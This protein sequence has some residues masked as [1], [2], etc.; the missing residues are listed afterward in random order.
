MSLYG[1]NWICGGIAYVLGFVFSKNP[2][3]LDTLD[4]KVGRY[5]A[6]CCACYPLRCGSLRGACGY[7]QRARACV[8]LRHA[9]TYTVCGMRACLTTTLQ[10]GA[11]HGF[12]KKH[13]HASL[14]NYKILKIHLSHVQE[15]LATLGQ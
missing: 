9:L 6:S 5:A 13:L 7:A 3:K 15:V 8:R 14:A 12:F 2:F 11:S 4:Y 10:N 1:A